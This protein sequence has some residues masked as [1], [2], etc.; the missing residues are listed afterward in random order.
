[1]LF[2]LGLV[3][4]LSIGFMYFRDLGDIS[5]MV[6]KVKRNNMIRFIRNEN[7]Y[8]AAG[9]GALIL[10]LVGHLMG[11]GPGGMGVPWSARQRPGMQR[12]GNQGSGRG[13]S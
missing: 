5:Q 9:I 13:G 10:M 11:G 4:S 7:A 8:L 6:L 12:G 1:M 3:V 2:Y